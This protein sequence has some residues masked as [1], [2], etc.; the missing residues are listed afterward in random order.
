MTL[1]LLLA[2]A[3]AAHAA[4]PKGF[5]ELSDRELAAELKRL[6]KKHKSLDERVEAV[7]ERFLGAQTVLGPLGEGKDGEYDRDPLVDF[8]RMDCTT[9]IEQVMALSLEPDLDKAIALLQKIRYKDGAIS[10][11][12][13]N[14]F[15][16]GDWVP[17]NV[18]AG[19]LQDITL[20]VAPDKAK[21]AIKKISKRDWYLQKSTSDLAGFGD[22]EA[23]K[24]RRLG[25]LREL[26][27][28]F[29][30][31]IAAL[32]YVP[33]EILP[34]V[35]DRIPSGTIANLVRADQPDKPSMI[36]HQVLLIRRDKVLYAR[37]A[38]L[39]REVA[40]VPALEYFYKYFNSKWP[41]L[42]LNLDAVAQPR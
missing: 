10:Y 25:H 26:G 36:S 5:H 20:R 41:L 32:P 4:P 3:L 33:I 7:S 24:E 40:D 14:H 1:S 9:Y 17:Q 18:R 37:H 2:A 39:G 31:Q 15:T 21:T 30:D 6:H 27:E 42:G 12:T 38:A 22:A 8:K 11:E 34:Q 19:F 23:E 28:R 16:E 35:A 29:Q 13:R